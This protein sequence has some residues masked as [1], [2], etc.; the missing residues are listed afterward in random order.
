MDHTR[1]KKT[2][3]TTYWLEMVDHKHRYGSNLKP[4]RQPINSNRLSFLKPSR[5]KHERQQET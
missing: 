5:R 3:D 1:A 2:M 4:Y